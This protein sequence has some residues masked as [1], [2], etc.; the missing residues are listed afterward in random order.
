V[1]DGGTGNN[2]VIQITSGG[3]GEN[4]SPSNAEA[5]FSTAQIGMQD[6]QYGQRVRDA[7]DDAAGA[8]TT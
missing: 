5:V 7:M 1:I 2:I 6:P 8:R 4:D 3:G